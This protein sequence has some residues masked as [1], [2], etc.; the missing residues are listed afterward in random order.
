MIVNKK[1]RKSWS[2]ELLSALYLMH[3][4]A[5]VWTDEY[6]DNLNPFN[7]LVYVLYMQ[8]YALTIGIYM[9]YLYV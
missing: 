2:P 9:E 8:I 5:D 1:K 7:H 3:F 4:M 6:T